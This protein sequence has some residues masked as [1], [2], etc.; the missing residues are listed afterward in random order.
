MCT[1]FHK[2]SDAGFTL[3]EVLVVLAVAGL[4]SALLIGRGPLRSS[5]VTFIATADQILYILRSASAESR[6]TGHTVLVTA[7]PVSR[8]VSTSGHITPRPVTLPRTVRLSLSADRPFRFMPDGSA[9]GPSLFLRENSHTLMLS[10]SAATG[11]V[12]TSEH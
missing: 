5:A 10:V 7:D 12:L 4:L 8:I 6:T 9:S 3:L 1:E 2:S 11:R